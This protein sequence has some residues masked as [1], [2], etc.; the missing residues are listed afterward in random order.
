MTVG[1]AM[2][3][4]EGEG[5]WTFPW[6]GGKLTFTLDTNAGTMTVKAAE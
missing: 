1:N 5:N 6:S 3:Y 2:S 4:Y